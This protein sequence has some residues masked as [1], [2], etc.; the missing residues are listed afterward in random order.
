MFPLLAV[1][2][3]ARL[4]GNS[5]RSIMQVLAASPCGIS[6]FQP[7]SLMLLSQISITASSVVMLKCIQ[8]SYFTYPFFQ[9]SVDMFKVLRSKLLKGGNL[10]GF[11][12]LQNKTIIC[13][14]RRE[15]IIIITMSSF[16]NLAL[17]YV[18]N[19]VNAIKWTQSKL[20]EKLHLISEVYCFSY[21]QKLYSLHSFSECSYLFDQWNIVC[22][23]LVTHRTTMQ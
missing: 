9:G 16:C 2:H 22:K 8:C 4:H 21:S 11:D 3:C 1:L 12:L 5:S 10:N 17:G 6:T 14:S 7:A 23:H 15:T 13:S 19:Q 18:S 20:A